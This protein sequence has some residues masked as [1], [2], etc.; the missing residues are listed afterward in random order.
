MFLRYVSFCISRRR[1]TSWRRFIAALYRCHVKLV[2]FLFS[3]EAYVTPDTLS[4]MYG[5]IVWVNM[6]MNAAKIDEHEIDTV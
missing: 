6:H 2:C 5:K 1:V 3:N 4:L